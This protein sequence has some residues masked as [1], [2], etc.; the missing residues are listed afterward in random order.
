MIEIEFEGMSFTAREATISRAVSKVGPDS[1][2]PE[3]L[4]SITDD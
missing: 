3:G 1:P 4:G 2:N